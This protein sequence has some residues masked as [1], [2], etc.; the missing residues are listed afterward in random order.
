LHAD[1]VRASDD[2]AS[3]AGFPVGRVEHQKQANAQAAEPEMIAKLRLEGHG[4][5]AERSV[6]FDGKPNASF[7][8]SALFQHDER[9]ETQWSSGFFVLNP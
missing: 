2:E 3:K 5:G 8:G 6:D 7:R 1:A 4:G 9:R